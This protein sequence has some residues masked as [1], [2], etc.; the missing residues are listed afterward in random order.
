MI[1]QTIH[2]VDRLTI[3]RAKELLAEQQC[4]LNVHSVEHCAVVARLSNV[5]VTS[6]N[7]SRCQRTGDSPRIA[8]NLRVVGNASQG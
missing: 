1:D 7:L 5:A 3:L 8:E 4:L 6:N 2:Q